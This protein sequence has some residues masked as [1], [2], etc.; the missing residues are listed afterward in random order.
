MF[1]GIYTAASAMLVQNASVDVAANNLA[2]VGTSGFRGRRA[3]NKAFPV[4]LMSRIEDAERREEP[5]HLFRAGGKIP[6]GDAALTT[7]LSET[8]LRTAAGSLAVTGNPLDVAPG[9]EGYFVVADERGNL[10]YTRSGHF[11]RDS[12]GRLVTHDGY[13]L[14][15]DG[16]NIELGEAERVVIGDGGQISADGEV[17]GNLRFVSFESPTWLRHVGKSLVAETEA[18]G[19][20]R[21]LENFR[22]VPGA[23]ELSNVHVVEEMVRMIDAH[24]AYEA[25]SKCVTAQDE[26]ASRLTTSFGRSG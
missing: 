15:G 3:V 6:I 11:T 4:L 21:E 24:R 2:N 26:S 20:P 10:F 1:R 5:E 25:S 7:V 13:F 9:E 14:Q 19:N 16:G 18:S 8:A 12:Q 17:I 22:L 23:L